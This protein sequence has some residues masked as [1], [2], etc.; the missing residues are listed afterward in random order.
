[1]EASAEYDGE[2][3][4]EEGPLAQSRWTGGAEPV[5]VDDENDEEGQQTRRVATKSDTEG[6]YIIIPCT[7]PDAL[8]VTFG[9]IANASKATQ[10]GKTQDRGSGVYVS[11]IVPRVLSD[12]SSFQTTLDPTSE[13]NQSMPLK[14]FRARRSS[15]SPMYEYTSLEIK[16]RCE[17]CIAGHYP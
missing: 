11:A 7:C 12:T 6:G 17:P 1:M 10:H 5:P 14:A 13:R 8:V 4:I 3:E 2:L 9:D 15:E 16:K